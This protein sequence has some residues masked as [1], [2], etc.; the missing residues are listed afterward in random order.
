M[1]TAPETIR[2]TVGQASPH[3]ERAVNIGVALIAFAVPSQVLLV[4]P[5]AGAVSNV[6][7][8]LGMLFCLIGL[9]GGAR[10]AHPSKAF[11]WLTAFVAFVGA[12]YF[13]SA[14][15][16][17]TLTRLVT[18][19]QLLVMALVLM[20][21]TTTLPRRTWA[22]SGY[23]GGAG[24]IVFIVL[25]NFVSK[26]ASHGSQIIARFSAGMANPN[27]IAGTLLVGMALAT[28]LV[29]HRS[30]PRLVWIAYLVLAPF[31][32][33]LTG[34]RTG[35]IGLLLTGTLSLNWLFMGRG[36]RRR[37][38][39]IAMI[40]LAIA[41][42]FVPETS[43][44]RSTDFSG[45]SYGTRSA[46]LRRGAVTT[47]LTSM[48]QT[49][50]LGTGAGTFPL[51]MEAE[52][53]RGMVAHNTFVS[54]GVEL[55]LT[56]LSLFLIAAGTAWHPAIARGGTDRW[57]ALTAAVAWMTIA[58][59]AS[60]ED[61]KVTWFVIAIIAAIAGSAPDRGDD[62]PKDP[63]VHEPGETSPATPLRQPA[64]RGGTTHDV[65]SFSRQVQ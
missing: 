21:L 3:A 61:D 19:V 35:L 13:W 49:P 8:P 33:L 11:G 28:W 15:P 34:S 9:S 30:R 37:G 20:T 14:D 18:Y 44:E 64:L 36:Q 52:N 51:A 31:A 27:R 2:P 26:S 32:V 5:G 59:F 45:S 23:V 57:L 29:T 65:G 55:G 7:L 16:D 53:Q 48:A 25:I 6:L 39:L 24:L 47:G 38:L 12:S 54:I 60:F 17:I 40:A 10:A 4:L 56:G 50:L 46:E 58:V 43:L 1:M 22:L 62:R 63:A 41:V 42:S